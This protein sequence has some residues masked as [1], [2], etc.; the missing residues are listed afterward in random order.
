M[1]GIVDRLNSNVENC[2][3]HSLALDGPWVGASKQRHG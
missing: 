3:I 2:I 1:E